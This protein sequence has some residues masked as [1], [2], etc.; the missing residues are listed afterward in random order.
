[1]P[2]DEQSQQLRQLVIG[3]QQYEFNRLFYGTS[4]GPTA[5]QAFMSNIFRPLILN[6]IAITNLDDDFLQ[7]QTKHEMFSVL[8]KLAIPDTLSRDTP[9]ES[10]TRKTTVETP[11]NIKFFLAKDELSPRLQGKYAV[12]TDVDQSQIHKLQQ[13]PLYLD[14]QYN[15]YEVDLLERSTFK[16]IPYSLWIKNKTQQKPV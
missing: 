10:L 16:T 13:C 2:L 8:E 15:H 9:P 7:S 6:K 1:M 4:I 3:N 5:F 11:Q 12:R 14:C